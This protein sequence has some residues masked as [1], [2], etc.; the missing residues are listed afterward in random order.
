[1]ET[2][3]KCDV[4]WTSIDGVRVPYVV[5]DD[6]KFVSVRLLETTLLANYQHMSDDELRKRAPLISFF[7]T[8]VEARALNGVTCGG[9]SE[10]DLIVQLTDFVM[11]Y[12]EVKSRYGRPCRTSGGWVQLNSTVMP[13]VITDGR[14]H[15]PLSV[16]RHAAML[17]KGVVVDSRKATHDE[18]QHLTTMCK[19]ANIPFHFTDSTRLVSVD[20]VAARS[21]TKAIVFDLPG[22]DPLAHAYYE[23][24]ADT[25]EQPI[26][27]P[28]P[29][30]VHQ[31]HVSR[32]TQ[33][34]PVKQSAA[35]VNLCPPL[36]NVQ[37]PALGQILSH[38]TPPG[39]P[40][41][42]N[43]RAGPP[44]TTEIRTL[45]APAPLNTNSIS[46]SD[47]RANLNP[48]SS[49][50]FGQP[51]PNMVVVPVI[52]QRGLSSP[53]AAVQGSFP[54]SLPRRI[55]RGPAP[56]ASATSPSFT[57][58]AAMP[59]GV[60]YQPNRVDMLKPD[61]PIPQQRYKNVQQGTVSPPQTYVDI[62]RGAITERDFQVQ[63]RH[64]KDHKKQHNRYL[65][66]KVFNDSRCCQIVPVVIHSKTVTCLVNGSGRWVLVEVI[67]RVFFP[68]IAI[69]DVEHALVMII[70]DGLPRIT[71][72][73]ETI[74]IR[75]YRLKTNAL[76][77]N[78]VV[79]VRDLTRC[80]PQLQSLFPAK[81]HMQ[82]QLRQQQQQIKSS[83]VFPAGAALPVVDRLQSPAS[84]SDSGIS[85][86]MTDRS[87]SVDSAYFNNEVLDLSALKKR[88]DGPPA[89]S[90][91]QMCVKRLRA[92]IEDAV[93]K[94]RVKQA[95]VT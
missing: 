54:R 62:T 85:V 76:A 79:R 32:E 9:Y 91:A 17:L 60:E 21:G 14:R 16:V 61:G 72:E 31:R 6:R 4:G 55:R 52:S 23:Y 19:K 63:L 24:V 25:P 47:A 28:L 53:D 34:V 8:P 3:G 89:D 33:L 90:D 36:L 83:R 13:Y 70:G 73:Q 71:P 5:R 67:A 92:G 26:P 94:L 69:G 11:F 64:H 49:V 1:M 30:S 87:D 12:G 78:T 59:W 27:L 38:G 68:H 18:S 7:M 82:K 56:S 37:Y 48:R 44:K 29:V 81:Q 74:F 84:E 95:F 80:L 15:V 50:V 41:P 20:V 22:E 40:V 46:G 75:F 58:P 43:S 88:K 45:A 39:Q 77:F 42:M 57:A 86:E 66:Q 10:H 93:A 35:G 2:G 65:P 51:P